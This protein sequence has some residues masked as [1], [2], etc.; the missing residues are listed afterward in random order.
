MPSKPPPALD[1]NVCSFS[2]I[3]V[4][5]IRLSLLVSNAHLCVIL[6]SWS[7]NCFLYWCNFFSKQPSLVV[8]SGDK[9]ALRSYLVLS[10]SSFFI[11]RACLLLC[12][13][14]AFSAYFTMYF[15]SWALGEIISRLIRSLNFPSFSFCRFSSAKI[16]N[17]FISCRTIPLRERMALVTPL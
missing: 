4:V 2:L 9:E 3:I 11:E 17:S 13:S 15:S 1:I 5:C 6:W 7:L 12:L 10:I 8:L 16:L 14:R